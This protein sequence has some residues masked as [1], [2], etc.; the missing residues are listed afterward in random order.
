MMPSWLVALPLLV[1]ACFH[2]TYD[3]PRCGPGRACPNGLVCN[4]D[5]I[6]SAPDDGGQ[7]DAS[8]D[9]ML[10]ASPSCTYTT[11]PFGGHHYRLTTTALTWDAARMD[12]ESDGGH[13][14]KVETAA[15][16]SF[17][18]NSLAGSTGRWI[19][20]RDSGALNYT[21][22]DGSQLSYTNWYSGAPNAGQCISKKGQWF[23]DTCSTPYVAVCECDR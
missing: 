10:D 22:Y 11:N 2:P 12:C 23:T 16:D 8:V 21:W 20:G 5:G 6:C 1:S 18:T 4:V 15:E 9:A 7:R 13:F 19:G 3:H 17:L 14:T